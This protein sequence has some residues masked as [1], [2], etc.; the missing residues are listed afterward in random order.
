MQIAFCGRHACAARAFFWHEGRQADISQARPGPLAK[1]AAG[2]GPAAG[3]VQTEAVR[4]LAAREPALFQSEDGWSLRSSSTRL[5]HWRARSLTHGPMSPGWPGPA[6]ISRGLTKLSVP[7]LVIPA[8]GPFVCQLG[9][10]IVAQNCPG[11]SSPSG[12]AFRQ[13]PAWS[14]SR[15]RMPA[16]L[17]PWPRSCQ[18]YLRRVGHSPY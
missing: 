9:P 3:C 5:R 11:R 15:T 6:L 13:K 8:R 4:L 14:F 16:C 12:G 1:A 17:A 18:L 2:R 10:G 7:F